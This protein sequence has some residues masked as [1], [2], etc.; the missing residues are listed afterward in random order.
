[1]AGASYTR[2]FWAVQP[3]RGLC[4]SFIRNAGGLEMRSQA[5]SLAVAVVS[6]SL[7]L[8][9]GSHADVWKCKQADGNILFSDRGGAE[10]QKVGSLPALQTV[11]FQAVRAPIEP[12]KKRDEVTPAPIQ[13]VSQPLSARSFEPSSRTVP[14]LYVTRMSP[15]LAAK[16]W[17]RPNQGDIA[18]VQIDLAHWSAGNGPYLGTDHHFRSV[19]RQTFAVAV[20]A[21]AKA[22]NYDPRFLQAQLTMPVGSILHAGEQIDGP[23]AGAAWAVAVAAALLGD[24]VRT[25]VCISGTIDISLA[26]GPVGGLEHKIEGCHMMRNIREMLLPAGQNTFAITDKGMA[27]SIKVT[28]VATL[29]EA[30]EIM[31][32]HPLRS[33]L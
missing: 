20:L 14:N 1:M 33:A 31:T 16:G 17:S 11:P 28:E 32:G 9:D 6:A 2:G 23:S 4:Y 19:P 24:P 5:F 30:Y 15:A 21:A 22:V 13:K 26:V 7:L 29:A 10:C 18:L 27:R 12:V 8:P 3:H 25:D